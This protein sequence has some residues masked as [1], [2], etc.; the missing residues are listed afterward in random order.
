MDRMIKK[1][2]KDVKNKKIEK[3][4]KELKTLLKMDKKQ[5]KKVDMMKKK[6]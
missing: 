5:D 4:G 1:I 6:C 2:E 3:S